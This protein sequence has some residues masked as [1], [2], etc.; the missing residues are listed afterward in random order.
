MKK[1]FFTLTFI[2]CCLTWFSG[3]GVAAPD[4]SKSS[5]RVRS[6]ETSMLD[7]YVD[8]KKHY[9][10]GG[11]VVQIDNLAPGIHHVVIKNPR[12]VTLYNRKL[13]LNSG[14]LRNILHNIEDS[15]ED[16]GEENL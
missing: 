13:M 15:M 3:S 10:G 8:G 7:V 1:Y 12:G 2:V 5:L 9:M 6:W 11:T 14:K 4:S 16:R